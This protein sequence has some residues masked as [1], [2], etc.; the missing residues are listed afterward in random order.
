MPSAT[1]SRHRSIRGPPQTR[2]AKNVSAKPIKQSTFANSTRELT[3]TEASLFDQGHLR[4]VKDGFRGPGCSTKAVQSAVHPAASDGPSSLHT[5][6]EYTQPNEVFAKNF[7]S[8]Y[9]ELA[10]IGKGGSGYVYEVRKW[11]ARAGSTRLACK[12]IDCTRDFNGMRIEVPEPESQTLRDIWARKELQKGVE[13]MTNEVVLWKDFNHPHLVKLLQSFRHGEYKIFLIMPLASW[14]LANYPLKISFDQAFI[15]ISQIMDAT[16][17]MHENNCTHRD[18]KPA[19]ILLSGSGEDLKAMVADFGISEKGETHVS[20]SGTQGFRAPEVLIEPTHDN[21]VDAWAIGLILWGMLFG[22]TYFVEDLSKGSNTINWDV[23]KTKKAEEAKGKKAKTK[24]ASNKVWLQGEGLLSSTPSARWTV[25]TARQH[26]LIQ[27]VAPIIASGPLSPT[28]AEEFTA[29]SVIPPTK[30]TLAVAG[31]SSRT[32][33]S[34]S[35][36]RKREALSSATGSH[37]VTPVDDF[38]PSS[39]QRGT[40]NTKRVKHYE[41]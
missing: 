19:N 27:N 36:K 8:V 4:S 41:K 38:E 5:K 35:S 9:E 40:R 2:S 30:H 10:R 18:L 37:Q 26:Y 13:R 3:P 34:T 33:A 16:I 7:Y 11:Q 29:S 32:R 21:K 39:K 20:K 6:V 22:P 23:I 14:S 25:K 1:P 15:L 17:Y 28:V 12:V 31:I 24:G